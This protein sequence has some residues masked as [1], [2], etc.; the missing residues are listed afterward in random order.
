M[1]LTNSCGTMT[2]SFRIGKRGCRIHCFDRL[3]DNAIGINGDIAMVGNRI[4]QKSM[5]QWKDYDAAYVDQLLQ[6]STI[7]TTQ[8]T[9]C[10]LCDTRTGNITIT[11]ASIPNG[12]TVIVKDAYGT[13]EDN[14]ITIV[15]NDALIDGSTEIILSNNYDSMRIFSTGNRFHI[16]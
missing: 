15:A 12:H 6:S 2:P 8:A 7:S 11:L 5:G 14:P 1:P 9:S 3:P 4:L 13:S 16:I 10:L